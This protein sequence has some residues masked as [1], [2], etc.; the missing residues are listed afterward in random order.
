MSVF[1]TIPV[2]F[3]FL[4]AFELFPQLP[5]DFAFMEVS[6]LEV[7]MEMESR[8][9]GG[10]NRFTHQLPVRSKY[11]DI[12]LKR[13]LFFESGITE[14]CRQAVENFSFTPTNVLISLLNA[15]HIP[16]NTWFVV[17]AIP[18]KWAVSN[19]NAMENTLAIESLTLSYQYFNIMTPAALIGDAVGA[20]ASAL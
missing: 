4:V 13:G 2:G 12:V 5:N 3:H 10:Q 8:K 6:G 20:I 17:N 1:D 7:E 11:S 16:V 15:D 18:K 9:E 19:F 14:W